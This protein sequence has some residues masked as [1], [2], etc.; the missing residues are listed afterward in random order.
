MALRDKIKEIISI[1]EESDVNE[2]EVS[3]WWGRKIRVVKQPAG[4][5]P[6]AAVASA[7]SVSGSPAP[8]ASPSSGPEKEPAGQA[9][10]S[11]IVGT[12]YRAASPE[13][14]PFINVGDPVKVGQIICIIEAMKIMNEI[15]SDLDGIVLEILPNNAG[16]VEFNEPLM[17][18]GPG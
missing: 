13:A 6:A 12:F 2:V 1:I 16:P 9:I 7:P 17:I 8:G 14:E 18:V 10:R 3:S 4:G 5:L 11:P 15:E